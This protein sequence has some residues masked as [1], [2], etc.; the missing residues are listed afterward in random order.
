M[1]VRVFYKYQRSNPVISSNLGFEFNINFLS[2]FNH[3]ISLYYLQTLFHMRL[4]STKS[5]K[6]AFKVRIFGCSKFTVAIL[7][8]VESF[9]S[10]LDGCNTDISSEA[11]SLN[12]ISKVL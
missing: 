7:G 6:V 12:W 2:D 9:L 4:F 5:R 3:Y 1:N 8:M 11:F 10:Q